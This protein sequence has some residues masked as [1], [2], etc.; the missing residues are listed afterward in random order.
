MYEAASL[1]IKRRGMRCLAGFLLCIISFAL[2]TEIMFQAKISC[3]KAAEG[4]MLLVCNSRAKPIY[5]LV[6]INKVWGWGPIH[7][8]SVGATGTSR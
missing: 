3:S 7:A 5:V 6:I 2:T 4:R 8:M 1:L